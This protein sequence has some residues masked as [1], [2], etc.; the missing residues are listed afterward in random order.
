MLSEDE[1]HVVAASAAYGVR[2]MKKVRSGLAVWLGCA[3]L[4]CVCTADCLA[5]QAWEK[6]NLEPIDHEKLLTDPDERARIEKRIEEY[7]LWYDQRVGEPVF[8]YH[9]DFGR[10]P[11]LGKRARLSA[12]AGPVFPPSGQFLAWI[13]V[14]PGFSILEGDK[15]GC[16]DVGPVKIEDL[17][18]IPIDQVSQRIAELQS[19]ATVRLRLDVVAGEEAVHVFR[20]YMV[21]QTTAG[22][23]TAGYRDFWV[24]VLEDTAYVSRSPSFYK[25]P[26]STG[27]ALPGSPPEE[28]GSVPT[29]RT[30]RLRK[31]P[32]P[33][34][35]SR[36][37]KPVVPEQVDES[38][39][40]QEVRK[41][42]YGEIE[43][44]DGEVWMRRAGEEE[45]HRVDTVEGPSERE[46]TSI[47]VRQ[48][49]VEVDVVDERVK[50]LLEEKLDV[51]V[52][53]SLPQRVR[54]KL[55]KRQIETLKKHSVEM[56]IGG[57]HERYEGYEPSHEKRDCE[58]M[59]QGST[60]Q[61][62]IFREDFETHVVPGP[63]WDAGDL[64]LGS[65]EDYWGD[66]WVDDD[67]RVRSGEWSCYCA[68]YSDVVGQQYDDN[69]DAYFST[70]SPIYLAPYDTVFFYFAAWYDTEPGYDS[71]MW[72]FSPNG[73]S[74]YLGDGW[75][76]NSGGWQIIAYKLWDFGN[77]YLK[78]AFRSDGT[79]HSYEGVY[80]DDIVWSSS[81][82]PNL[83]P[84][85][86]TGWDYPVV[87]S[88][89]TGT[90][91]V[92]DLYEDIQTYIDWAV[93]NNGWGDVEDTF[94]VFLDLDDELI[95]GWYATSLPSGYYAPL[96]DSAYTV[97]DSGLHVLKVEVDPFDRIVEF[98]EGD[99]TYE[100]QFHWRP[101]WVTVGGCFQ[102]HDDNTASDRAIPYA[103]V[104]L[105]SSP[106]STDG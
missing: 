106:A 57:E 68:D 9:L 15:L 100:R 58:N 105:W 71:L 51:E 70:K 97:A 19:E 3:L 16:T 28:M 82:L 76:G 12:S 78:F 75:S 10:S 46:D 26:G 32:S 43:Y 44:R 94:Y 61:T 80:I 69:M 23:L 4:T 29:W 96:E 64:D 13:R 52:S 84:Y 24:K 73:S 41:L 34:E 54:L 47:E 8:A 36:P 66:Q 62:I 103:E 72:Y 5:R 86:P 37:P 30:K 55:D 90:H 14:P 7:Q 42:Y 104:R 85:R 22:S 79:S 60:S 40:V 2:T 53:A 87:P 93:R 38:Y 48:Y 59:P 21:G 95:G 39:P 98:N 101:A 35:V 81:R 88:S 18:A 74:W 83:Y 49:E 33:P 89:V 11:S 20:V 77:L 102:Y 1:V 99:N 6:T 92:N 63:V 25:W 50:A 56:R 91:T 27:I 65:G 45:F 67:A 31:R 17:D